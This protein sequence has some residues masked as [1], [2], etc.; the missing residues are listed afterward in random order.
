[1]V[2][3]NVPFSSHFFSKSFRRLPLKASPFAKLCE[4]FW[5][6]S[7]NQQQT[8]LAFATLGVASLA[9]AGSCL[10]YIETLGSLSYLG[11]TLAVFLAM[12]CATRFS[13]LHRAAVA[14]RPQPAAKPVAKARPETSRARA[15]EDSEDEVI[16]SR[17]AALHAAVEVE[18]APSTLPPQHFEAA[19]FFAPAEIAP[20][21]SVVVTEEPLDPALAR[22]FAEFRP[23]LAV[24][25]EVPNPVTLR[26]MDDIRAQIARLREES[27]ARHAANAARAMARV[28]GPLAAPAHAM[29]PHDAGRP[30]ASAGTDPFARTEFSGL[31]GVQL[32]SF[33]RTEFIAPVELPR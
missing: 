11:A 33:A 26:Q 31:P 17:M 15:R 25:M 32:A 6:T 14:A 21:S 13:V 4:H 24:Q 16:E 18:D 23:E 3:P 2:S 22:Q 1:M 27:R 29:V 7:M 9:V 30:D 10:V 28:P 19:S 8:G 12:L 20:E 5:G